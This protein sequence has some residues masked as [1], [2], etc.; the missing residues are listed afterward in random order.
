MIL[1]VG[2]DVAVAT[3]GIEDGLF[4][5]MVGQCLHLGEICSVASVQVSF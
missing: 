4:T 2:G 1:K 5:V 3:V